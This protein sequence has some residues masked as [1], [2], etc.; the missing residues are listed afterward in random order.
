MLWE[1]GW[2]KVLNKSVAGGGFVNNCW[3][4]VTRDKE[5]LKLINQKH[6]ELSN[7]EFL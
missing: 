5:P 3:K 1:V 7:M 2:D 4:V 6:K